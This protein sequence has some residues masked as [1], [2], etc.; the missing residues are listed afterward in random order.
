MRRR[1]RK[2]PLLAKTVGIGVL[3]TLAVLP[4]LAKLGLFKQLHE[5]YVHTQLIN[6]PP[7]PPAP[8]E[9]KAKEKKRVRPHVEGKRGPRITHS[10]VAVHVQAG[11]SSKGANDNGNQ[12]VNAPPGGPVGVAPSAPPSQQPSAVPVPTPAV[13]AP[14]ASVVPKVTAA[15]PIEPK[16]D[17]IVEAE[18]VYQPAPIIPDDLLDSDIDMTFFGY[19]DVKPDGTVDVKM[20][21]STGNSILD[22]LAMDAAKQWKFTPATKNGV[23]VESYRRLQVEFVVS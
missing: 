21:Q 15:P 20:V 1:N 10:T 16:A 7:P 11:S 3:V 14:P 22:R 12:I 2:N 13:T 9:E 5:D 6:L 19:F 8:K 4:I 18:P 23:P 17:I